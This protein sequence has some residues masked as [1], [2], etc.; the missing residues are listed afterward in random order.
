LQ[1]GYFNGRGYLLGEVIKVNIYEICAV[2]GAIAFAV[3]IIYL[4]MLLY[5]I[6]KTFDHANDILEQSK[7]IVSSITSKIEILNLFINTFKDTSKIGKA[8][9]YA[10]NLIKTWKNKKTE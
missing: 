5:A 4:C 8:I 6:K 10:F 7:T 9:S 1:R 2:V 3:S